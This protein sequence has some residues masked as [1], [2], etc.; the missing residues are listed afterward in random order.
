[1]LLPLL[2]YSKFTKVPFFKIIK[3]SSLLTPY[4][5][6]ATGSDAASNLSTSSACISMDFWLTGSFSWDLC[7]DC[8]CACWPCWALSVGGWSITTVCC[9]RDASVKDLVG[10]GNVGVDSAT[11]LG[12][13]AVVLAGVG[14]IWGLFDCELLTPVKLTC[15]ALP[16][17]K[18]AWEG[19]PAAKDF[20]EFCTPDIDMCFSCGGWLGCGA[21]LGCVCLA[22]ADWLN[23][24]CCLWKDRS[25]GELGG[26]W[27]GWPIYWSS[28]RLAKTRK[29]QGSWEILRVRG[30]S[31][32][33]YPSFFRSCSPVI[34]HH[35]QGCLLVGKWTRTSLSR[36]N[37]A[38][39]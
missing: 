19:L 16:A 37:I 31:P 1:M 27:N 9:L 32:E 25:L 29:Y 21:A 7:A 3:I 28:S 4:L 20:W 26:G 5:W 8:S 36:P 34:C 35:G 39:D 23:C 13:M 30:L 22:A 17:A 24:C 12:L 6:E 38:S 14:G 2:I 10:D 33:H 15:D 11:F 18:L